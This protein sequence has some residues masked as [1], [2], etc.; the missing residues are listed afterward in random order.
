MNLVAEV[1]DLQVEEKMEKTKITFLKV[2]EIVTKKDYIN[3]L[4]IEDLLSNKE[5]MK[6]NLID[7]IQQLEEEKDTM[8]QI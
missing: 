3:H 5:A 1:L 8:N 4:T 2:N 6:I 7:L